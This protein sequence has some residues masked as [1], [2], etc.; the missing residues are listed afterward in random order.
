MLNKVFLTFISLRMK[1][2]YVSIQIKALQQF[3][4]CLFVVSLLMLVQSLM[5]PD[6]SWCTTIQTKGN[7]KCSHVV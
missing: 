7:E 6:K 4:F 1:L 5:F 3:S 2:L